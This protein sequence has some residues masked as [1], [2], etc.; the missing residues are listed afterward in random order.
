MRVLS[1]FFKFIK[2]QD[3]EDSVISRVVGPIK[4]STSTN[5]GFLTFLSRLINNLSKSISLRAGAK[6][7]EDSEVSEKKDEM[8]E[9]GTII[10]TPSH[11]NRVS[12]KQNLTYEQVQIRRSLSLSSQQ[13]TKEEEILPGELIAD[14]LN[15]IEAKYRSE[16]KINDFLLEVSKFVFT[17]EICKTTLFKFMDLLFALPQKQ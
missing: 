1:D 10:S 8:T 12:S 3:T 16:P 17:D 11:P 13:R 4:L 5:I 14:I 6:K 15:I 9:D 7:P 2:T